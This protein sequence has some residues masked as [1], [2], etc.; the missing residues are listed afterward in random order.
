MPKFWTIYLATG[1]FSDLLFLCECWMLHSGMTGK[2]LQANFS[3][4]TRFQGK[5]AAVIGPCVLGIVFP[6][7]VL[8]G[9]VYFVVRVCQ[10]RA[11][12]REYGR[13]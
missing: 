7:Y 1:V 13:G 2:V 11:R 3:R 5:P 6:P 4:V 10:E 12:L 8:G 9:L